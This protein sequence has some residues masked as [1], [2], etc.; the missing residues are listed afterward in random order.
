MARLSAPKSPTNSDWVSDMWWGSPSGSIFVPAGEMEFTQRQTDMPGRGYRS[1]VMAQRH[2]PLDIVIEIRPAN[3]DGIEVETH[4][5]ADEVTGGYKRVPTGRVFFRGPIA[6]DIVGRH[7]SYTDDYSDTITAE[8]IGYLSRLEAMITAAVSEIT[9]NEL[10]RLA[11]DREFEHIR[12]AFT[13]DQ[14]GAE[15][16][17]YEFYGELP[18]LG[19]YSA[20]AREIRSRQKEDDRLRNVTHNHERAV[21]TIQRI[22]T[23]LS[24]YATERGV[25]A[26]AWADQAKF[27]A[28][29][30]SS[31]NQDATAMAEACA[32]LD[33]LRDDLRKTI[34]V[35]RQSRRNTAGINLDRETEKL[36]RKIAEDQQPKH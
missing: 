30:L 12:Q 3:P 13:G 29:L 18:G 20:M 25:S 19:A 21:K 33:G 5:P 34:R 22:A 16:T 7:A 36:V 14:S 27:A 11:T 15:A 1:L 17:R 24:M 6:G 9:E 8:D 31:N 4:T 2:H 10:L 23:S 26:S 28:D 32:Q 35:L